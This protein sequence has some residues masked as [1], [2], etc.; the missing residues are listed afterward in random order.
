SYTEIELYCVLLPVCCVL[1]LCAWSECVRRTR[2]SVQKERE[3]ERDD[4]STHRLTS[5][6]K[7]STAAGRVG[8]EGDG[9]NQ[10]RHWSGAY[11]SEPSEEA[12]GSGCPFRAP[13]GKQHPEIQSGGEL[14]EKQRGEMRARPGWPIRSQSA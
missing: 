2:M 12:G 13:R 14:E 3:R 7:R 4:L 11:Q 5:K 1:L 8:E 9:E 6:V 10:N